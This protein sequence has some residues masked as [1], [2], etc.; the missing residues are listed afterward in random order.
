MDLKVNFSE[1]ISVGNQVS[2]KGAEFQDLLN[3]IKSINAELQTYWEGT[4][5]S[6]YTNA[7]AEQAQDMQKLTDAINEIGAF[8]VKVGEAYREA[9]E[10]NA[11]AIRS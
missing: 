6:K 10:N 5:A 4:D 2:N 9:S 1:T 7:V 8:L 11:N 3:K